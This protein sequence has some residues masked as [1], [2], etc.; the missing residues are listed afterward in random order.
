M[1]VEAIDKLTVLFVL[2]YII[3]ILWALLAKASKIGKCIQKDYDPIVK[4]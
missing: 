1:I 3:M 2:Y 4:E